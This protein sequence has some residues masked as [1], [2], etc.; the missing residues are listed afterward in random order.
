MKLDNYLKIV[1]TI[2]AACFM[3]LCVRNIDFSSPVLAQSSAK[4]T[5]I[6][7]YQLGWSD[8]RNFGVVVLTLTDGS[9]KNVKIRSAA[10]LAG[11]AAVLNQKPVYINDNGD[12]FTG[13]AIP[14]E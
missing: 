4:K 8:P 12:I 7:S 2:I 5:E 10:D 13:E 1:L 14:K 11:W 9:K 6:K 3:W